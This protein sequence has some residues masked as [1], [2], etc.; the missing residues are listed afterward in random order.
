MGRLCDCGNGVDSL[1]T[2]FTPSGQFNRFGFTDDGPS[3]NGDE[4]E[5]FL[6]YEA[7]C[8]SFHERWI[9][10]VRADGV[11]D[12]GGN[13]IWSPEVYSSTPDNGR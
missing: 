7:V 10:E 9:V 4:M 6:G 5:T 12:G 8:V 11:L 1:D 13:I 3:L 2:G